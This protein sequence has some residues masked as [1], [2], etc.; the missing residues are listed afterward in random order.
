MCCLSVL[1]LS[2]IKKQVIGCG[3]DTHL[4]AIR[5][6]ADLAIVEAADIQRLDVEITRKL[7]NLKI[8]QGK[9]IK[10]C[11]PL[12]LHWAREKWGDKTNK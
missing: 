12:Q 4:V 6:G 7:G 5:G 2:R 3:G 10:S 9:L 11:K 8:K 1:L